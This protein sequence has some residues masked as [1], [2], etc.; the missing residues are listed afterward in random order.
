MSASAVRSGGVQTSTQA[1]GDLEAQCE[2]LRGANRQLTQALDETET[3]TGGL[4][5]AAAK[6]KDQID[7]LMGKV[8]T[9]NED[10]AQLSRELEG[11]R[12]RQSAQAGK[13]IKRDALVFA[14]GAG[15]GGAVL[16]LAMAIFKKN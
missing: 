9:Q 11:V 5:A 4:I 8:R 15:S 6:Q 13:G 2:A 3:R 1:Q 16:L 12:I 10:L 7:W 14:A